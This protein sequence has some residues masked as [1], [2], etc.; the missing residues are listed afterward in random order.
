[1]C[2]FEYCISE[3]GSEY[4]N[5]RLLLY[6]EN[7]CVVCLFYWYFFCSILEIRLSVLC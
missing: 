5:F 3:S 2:D 7:I 4:N 1:M 6:Y